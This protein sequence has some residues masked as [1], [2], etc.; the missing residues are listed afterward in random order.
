VNVLK[1]HLQATLFTLLERGQSQREIY[2]LTGIDRKTIRKYERVYRARQ[3]ARN[4]NSPGVATGSDGGTSQIPPPWPPA[5]N[6]PADAQRRI[7]VAARSEC[8]PHRCRIEEQVRLKRNAKAILVRIYERVIEIR[9]HKTQALR[10]THAR[11][12]RPGSLLLPESERPFNPSRQ[13]RYL[14][15][16]AEAI[17]PET[18]AL[19]Q[20]LFDT[21]GRV[22][23][24][25][26]WGIVA[27]ADKYPARIFE[28][29]C[30]AALAANVRSC[31][32]LRAIANRLLEQALVRLDQAP[33]S[34]LP[35]TQEMS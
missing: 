24:R 21:Q 26:M 34:E 7:A 2:R 29:A 14:I 28:Q 25:S 11:A 31:R 18:H 9:D 22:G 3:A 15:A 10:R 19:C 1:P 33:Q 6:A 12:D 13:T 17:G 20:R 5:A 32:Q 27:L 23:Q 8:E 4:L 35:L 16:Q 30:A